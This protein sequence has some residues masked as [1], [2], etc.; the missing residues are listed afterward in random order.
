MLA[1][2]VGGLGPMA[3]AHGDLHEQIQIVSQEIATA[4]SALLYLKRGGLFH[5]HEEYAPALAD[6]DRAERLD[7]SLEAIWFARGRTFFKSGQLAKARAALDTYLTRKPRHAGAFLLRARVLSGLTHYREAVRDFDQNLSL[8]PQPLPE[9]FLERAEALVAMD[10]KRVALESLDEGI[11]RL[12]NLV[13]LQ[14][15]AIAIELALGRNNAALAR[16]DRVLADLQRKETWLVRRGE[17]L[18]A[19][20]R[21]DEARQAFADALRSI[22]RLPAHHRDTKATRDLQARLQLKLGS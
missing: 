21:H 8:T 6:Y 11:H 14:N 9:C 17:I 2:V 10:E 5:D 20:G 7:P 1:I 15:A 12:G 19:A 18:E 3:H 16:V 4:P 22:D 13:T